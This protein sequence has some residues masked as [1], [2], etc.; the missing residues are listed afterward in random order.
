MDEQP[1]EITCTG[2]IAIHLSAGDIWK[3]VQENL[4][5][6]DRKFHDGGEIPE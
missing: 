2:G 1:E 4:E 5:K 3:T 6:W